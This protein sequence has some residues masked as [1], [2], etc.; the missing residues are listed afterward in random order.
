MG[1]ARP[2]SPCS[3]LQLP[4]TCYL[5]RLYPSWLWPSAYKNYLISKWIFSLCRALSSSSLVNSTWLTNSPIA[6]H[7]SWLSSIASTTVSGS[8]ALATLSSRSRLRLCYRSQLNIAC[9]TSSLEFLQSTH[10][11]SSLHL[12]LCRYSPK[13]PCPVSICTRWK[14]TLPCD[15]PVHLLTSRI[16]WCVQ[17][18]VSATSHLVCHSVINWALASFLFAARSRSPLQLWF[19]ARSRASRSTGG[20]PETTKIAWVDTILYAEATLSGATLLIGCSR[21]FLLLLHSSAVDHTSAAYIACPITTAASSRLLPWEGPTML[22]ISL[23]R[24]ALNAPWSRVESIRYVQRYHSTE[25]SSVQWLNGPVVDLVHY[26][27]YCVYCGYTFT[28]AI[29][30]VPQ[31]VVCLQMGF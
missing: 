1:E 25:V 17:R 24:A 16:R 27:R 22:G 28:K 5:G 11:G 2:V 20:I 19:R 12:N 30:L 26:V 13:H 29:L 4:F 15:R 14:S 18:P 21:I 3:P 23:E 10:A 8:S 31:L 7:F 9:S 6:L